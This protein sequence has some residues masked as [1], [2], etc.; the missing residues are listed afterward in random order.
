MKITKI[1]LICI[2]GLFASFTTS[3]AV[4]EN[5]PKNKSAKTT[6]NSK[7]TVKRPDPKSVPP[8]AAIPVEEDFKV[9]LP[10]INREFRGVWIA[11]VANIN[12]PSRNNLSVEQQKNGS[13]QYVEYAPGK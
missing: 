9:N 11:S 1:K 6:N 2:L 3:C 13:D 12:W 5:T 4:R 7:S 8:I 10:A